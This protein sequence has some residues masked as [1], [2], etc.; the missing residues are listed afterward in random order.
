MKHARH[1]L[2]LCLSAFLVLGVGLGMSPSVA[3]AGSDTISITILGSD[4]ASKVDDQV[5]TFLS[6][7]KNVT[8]D[9]NVARSKRVVVS[10]FADMS[11][12]VSL[13]L[14][15]TVA[16][17]P[18]RPFTLKFKADFTCNSTPIGI[19]LAVHEATGLEP[20]DNVAVAAALESNRLI[21]ERKDAIVDSL[22]AALTSVT[23]KDQLRCQ[24]LKVDK[25]GGVT[26]AFTTERL[27]CSPGQKRHAPCG[28]NSTGP[29]LDYVC[30]DNKWVFKG[31][32]CEPIPPPGGTTP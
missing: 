14:V 7:N 21:N 32:T 11:M 31:G 27:V 29:G 12:L 19:T 5:N 23:V 1:P 22:E 10:K 26:V 30:N 17:F 8:W 20:I 3:Q 13:R 28:G 25:T 18:L 6:K 4:V 9:S 16:G 24:T 15:A 2:A